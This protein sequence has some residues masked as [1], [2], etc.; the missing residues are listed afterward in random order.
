MRGRRRRGR[1]RRRGRWLLRIR[2]LITFWGGDML[3]VYGVFLINRLGFGLD[4]GRYV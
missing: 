3:D 2:C 4:A 1:G